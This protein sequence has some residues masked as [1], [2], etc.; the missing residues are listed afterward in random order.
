MRTTTHVS[1]LDPT[2]IRR[3]SPLA[4]EFCFVDVTVCLAG[5]SPPRR[6]RVTRNG[7]DALAV[8]WEP[9]DI[10][11]GNVSSYTLRAIAVE[12]HASEVLPP[13][14]NQVQGGASNVTTLRGLQPGTKYNVSVTAGNTRG[15]SDATYA[16]EWTAIGPPDKP[17]VPKILKRDGSAVTVLL[18]EG[19][20]ERG[21]I[22]A[23]QVV[24]VQAGAIPPVD[25]DVEYT[26]YKNALDRGLNCYVAAE[27]DPSDF[28]RY[29]K[30]VVGDGK[31][32]GD[33]YNAPLRDRFVS[34]RVG[35]AVISRVRKEVQRAYS[36]LADNALDRDATVANR[37]DLTAFLLCVAIT[38]VSILLAASVLIYFVLRRR[39]ETFRVRKLPEQQELTLQGPMYEVDNV[40]Y[41]P[42]DVPERVNHYLELR[43]KVWSIPRHSLTIDNFL[44]RRGRFGTVHTG[45]VFKDD[46]A[47]P[48]TVHAIADGALKGSEKRHML[49]ELDVCIRAGTVKHLAGL[50]GTCEIPDTLYIVHELPP[51]IL[52][53]CLLAVRSGDDTFP[54]DRILSIASSIATALRYLANHKVVH[55]HLCARSVGL[56][57]DWTPK[58]MG[59]GIAKYGLEDIKYTRWTAIECFD[60][61]K[62]Q[63]PGVIWAFGVL[64]WEMFSMG[65]TPYSNLT[66]DSEV[67]DA[68]TRGVRLSQLLDIPDPIYEVMSSCWRDDSEERPLFDELT[69]LVRQL[70][71]FT[72]QLVTI[73]GY[74]QSLD[75]L[76]GNTCRHHTSY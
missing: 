71:S 57:D 24:I 50:V 65:G 38:I 76:D 67:E 7:T 44:V 28:H 53:S 55:T 75:K 15:F 11:N 73:L 34:A 20:S 3:C 72:V 54:V 22:S 41:I 69:R 17:A 33:Y 49:R 2:C 8:T 51:R 70:L 1:S 64:L 13:V 45:T 16:V 10:P 60:D 29:Q 46:R 61:R 27:F 40:G 30:F 14:E 37:M 36:D 26:D 58:L 68:V 43:T 48:V 4:I 12:T 63:Q 5:P 39:H 66:L 47:Q 19:R 74:L 35:L 6:I 9:P 25:A 59:H 23:Y 42:D 18:T 32:I 21:P 62:K 52:K 31:L 56:C